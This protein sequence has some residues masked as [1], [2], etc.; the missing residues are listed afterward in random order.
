M[1]GTSC[2]ET[3]VAQPFSM[4]DVFWSFS[5]VIQGFLTLSK[6][7]KKKATAGMSR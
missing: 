6:V 7:L 1:Q 3:F 4:D 2:T 5:S